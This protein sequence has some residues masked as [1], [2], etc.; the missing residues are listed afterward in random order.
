M[1]IARH[2][3]LARLQ[4]NGR[5]AD[6]LSHQRAEHI[7]LRRSV[8]GIRKGGAR[9]PGCRL[10]LKRITDDE[11]LQAPQLDAK[12]VGL[13][14]HTANGKAAVAG[15]LDAWNGDGEAEAGGRGLERN[16]AARVHA[17]IHAAEVLGHEISRVPGAL[18]GG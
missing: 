14:G 18:G 8:R 3:G 4:E 13:A 15:R 6:G 16:V 7:G 9:G 17:D 2:V 12:A 1:N 10:G 11:V 5:L